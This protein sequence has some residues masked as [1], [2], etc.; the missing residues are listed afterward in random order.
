MITKQQ[1]WAYWKY[2]WRHKWFVFR[3]CLRVG[4]IPLWSAIV[5]DWDKF[6][7]G[8]FL[9]YVRTFY[10]PDGSGRYS[11]TPE[12]NSA[13]NAH[14]K[15]NRHHWQYWLLTFDRGETVPL[16]MPEKDVREMIADW[17][18]AGEAIGKP[19]T[20]DWYFRNKGG[21]KLHPNTT[22]RVENLLMEFA[23]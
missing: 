4:G 8:M 12:F 17:M 11:E 14:Q 7:P 5:H 20:T 19:N 18:G 6:L 23:R 9:S 16:E 10:N 21:M 22:K 13:W 3:H 2:V 1:F 15:R